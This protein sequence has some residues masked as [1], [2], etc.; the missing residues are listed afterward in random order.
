MK[1]ITD[2]ASKHYLR[3]LPASVLLEI[4]RKEAIE[5]LGTKWILHPENRVARTK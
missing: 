3:Q 4:K 2:Y 1:P 5:R